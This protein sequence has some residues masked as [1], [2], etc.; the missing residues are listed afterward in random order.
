MKQFDYFVSKF[1]Q[2]FLS[3]TSG[4]VDAFPHF[5]DKTAF[6][7]LVLFQPEADFDP[8]LDTQPTE[9][10]VASMRSRMGRV[11]ADSDTTL[12]GEPVVVK[13]IGGLN[14]KLNRILEHTNRAS[15]ER[16]LS[17]ATTEVI[18][19]NLILQILSEING[20]DT[21]ADKQDHVFQLLSQS[22][23]FNLDEACAG[24]D[25]YENNPYRAVAEKSIAK[26]RKGK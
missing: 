22:R 11:F 9:A 16:Y 12:C 6:D 10:E 14:A 25:F 20:E 26:L 8:D 18:L 19:A 1:D 21:G 17:N 4:G 5:E 13:P 24:F 23:K 15:N 2:D 3:M 7:D